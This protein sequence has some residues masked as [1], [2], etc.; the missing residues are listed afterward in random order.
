[1]KRWS[2][3]PGRGCSS[4]P[5]RSSFFV[6]GVGGH[7]PGG[8]TLLGRV[9]NLCYGKE[10]SFFT[11]RRCGLRSGKRK[12][13]DTAEGTY[14]RCLP[15]NKRPSLVRVGGWTWAGHGCRRP[16]SQAPESAISPRQRHRY[17]PINT[18]WQPPKGK[19]RLTPL[20]INT[21]EPRSGL[22]RDGLRT[23]FL[24]LLCSNADALLKLFPLRE[25]SQTFVTPRSSHGFNSGMIPLKNVLLLD[26]A[27]QSQKKQRSTG[28]YVFSQTQTHHVVQRR[29]YGP[30]PRHHS[31][32]V[33]VCRT[34]QYLSGVIL[35]DGTHTRSRHS[36]RPASYLP[37]LQEVVEVY[38]LF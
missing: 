29:Q 9:R 28:G 13:L 32:V 18:C 14:K 36:G 12:A 37:I 22:K 35:G 2:E 24:S 15:S 26:L 34:L 38:D 11:D 8:P 20:V 31:Q 21:D 17:Q 3:L 27:T 25:R 7:N 5:R 19:S 10:P 1:M 16:Q 6:W 4:W 33:M 23:F 30:A